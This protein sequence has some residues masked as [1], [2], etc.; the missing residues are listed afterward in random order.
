MLLHLL[1]TGLG[2]SNPITEVVDS[3]GLTL[4]HH[5]VLKGVDGKTQ[6]LID[7]AKNKQEI[8]IEKIREWISVKTAEEGWQAIHYGAF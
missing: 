2:D 3:Q 4:L 6:F 5:A 1:V 8:S 7:F